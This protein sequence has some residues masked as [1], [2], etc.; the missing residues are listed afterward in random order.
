[1]A[2]FNDPRLFEYVGSLGLYVGT[3]FG[4]FFLTRRYFGSTTA[5]LA[6]AVYAF[7]ELGLTAGSMLFLTHATR[8]FFVWMIYCV[9]RWVDHN[10]PKFLAGAILIWATGMYVFMEMAPAI[11][12]IPVVWLVYRPPVGVLHVALAAVLA[13][14]LW[15]PYLRFEAQ[16]NFIDVRSQVDGN[17]LRRP[18]SAAHGA[19]KPCCHNSGS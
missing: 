10:D 14:G 13:I 5:L 7:S 4:I 19:T 16:R 9:G 8:C 17:Q 1:L 12:V 6:V 2:V 3:L 11:L 15:S 18:I